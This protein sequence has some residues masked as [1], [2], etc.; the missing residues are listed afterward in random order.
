MFLFYL[1]SFLFGL[2]IGSF[3][4]CLIYRLENEQTLGGRSYCPN[5]KHQLAWFDLIPVVSYLMLL[6]K[7]RYCHKKISIQYPIVEIATGIAFLLIFTVV[8]SNILY[9]MLLW[10]VFASFTVIFIF[11]IKY[12]IIP[13]RILF[14]AIIITL[15]YE[16]LFTFP[17]FISNTLWAAVLAS[18]FFLAI[19][20]VSRGKWMGFGDVKLAILMGLILGFPNILSGLFLSFCIGSVVGVVLMISQKKGLK[21]EMPFAP[22]LIIGTFLALFFGNI[23]ASWYL[24]H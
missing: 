1:F 15:L 20:L 9:L 16:I 17:H 12:Y 10:Y 4:N 22:F 3:L 13:D 2:I 8:P 18:G 21:N 14:P 11:D 19:F 23:I 24:L 6:G 7:C 5:C